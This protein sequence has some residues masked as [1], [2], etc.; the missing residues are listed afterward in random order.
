MSRRN[1]REQ[2]ILKEQD[3]VGARRAERKEM[4]EL[5]GKK[6]SEAAL[7]KVQRL[8]EFQ[9]EKSDL[10]ARPARIARPGKPLKR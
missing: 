4:E 2:R 10:E 6:K 5:A 7:T 8:R 1:R 9:K 3:T